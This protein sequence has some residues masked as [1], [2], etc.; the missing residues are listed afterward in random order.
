MGLTFFVLV[1]DLYVDETNSNSFAKPCPSFYIHSNSFLKPD[2][3]MYAFHLPREG[4][5][6]NML[7][8]TP[9]KVTEFEKMW[10]YIEVPSLV[11][12]LWQL[13]LHITTSFALNED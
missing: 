8:V 2:S 12:D 9:V 11:S 13:F 1:T 4:L 3:Y 7:K 10:N 6:L 5:Q